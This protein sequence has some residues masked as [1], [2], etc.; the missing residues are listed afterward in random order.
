MK[1]DNAPT[2][3]PAQASKDGHLAD[4]AAQTLSPI[5]KQFVTPMTIDT[6]D[7]VPAHQPTAVAA[8]SND[9]GKALTDLERVSLTEFAL[10]TAAQNVDSELETRLPESA[11][12]AQ[13]P[14]IVA[15]NAGQTTIAQAP[16]QPMA[17]NGIGADQ[18]P[19]PIQTPV[20]HPA[21]SQE[22]GDRIVWM[23]GKGQG[24]G[25]QTAEIK[26]NPAHL[27]PVE[28][29]VH[30]NQDQASVQFVSNHAAIRE[31]IESAVP[32]LR[33]MLSAQQLNLADV[34]VSPQ[35]QNGGQR[36][37]NTAAQFGFDQQSSQQR[38]TASFEN[39]FSDNSQ[40]QT[41]ALET[42]V[43]VKNGLLSLY[44]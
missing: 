13:L 21:W 44:A 18:Q 20:D 35:S 26:L 38:Q 37:H 3:S 10:P 36:N 5:L 2:T 40:P 1:L 7:K 28:V 4:S 9:F 22:L 19:A 25:L 43:S 16:L 8:P 14:P 11:A 42:R 31:A 41:T 17:T 30:M 12:S 29:R 6:G 27:G 15:M 34:N 32:K 39:G 23:A 33:E 24:Q